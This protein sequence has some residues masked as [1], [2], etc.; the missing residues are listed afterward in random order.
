MSINLDKQQPQSGYTPCACRDCMDTT[1]SSDTGKPE[2][3]AECKEAGCVVHDVG[4]YSPHS[5][6][7]ECQREDAY[8]DDSQRSCGC[9]GTGVHGVDHGDYDES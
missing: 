8:D 5:I 1:V 2:L 4:E 3:C 7:W 6:V 9:G